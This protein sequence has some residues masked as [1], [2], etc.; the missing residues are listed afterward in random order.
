MS[1]DNT[2][3][4]NYRFGEFSLDPDRQT[5]AL[6]DREVHLRPKSFAVLMSL[7]ERSGQLVTKQML[8]DAAWKE[9]AVSDDSLAHCIADI[10][11]ALGDSGHEMIRTVP[12]RGYIFEHPVTQEFD[13][14]PRPGSERRLRTS[15]VASIALALFATT[16]LLAGFGP[17]NK[18][19]EH[20]D[21]SAN[22]PL[23]VSATD[24][25]NDQK[26]ANSEYQRGRFFF[27][28]RGSG[29]LDRAEA[30]FKRALELDPSYGAA[31]TG[32]AGL[33]S[34]RCAHGHTSLD[35][36]LPILGD[37]TRNAVS[38]APGSA[39]AHARRAFYYRLR[40]KHRDS[41]H[42]FDVALA[43]APDN[44]HMLAVR[45]GK[46]VERGHLDEAIELQ[47]QAIE[48]RPTS[49]LLQH[50]LTWYLLAA[51]R[52]AEAAEEARIYRALDPSR[53]DDRASIFVDVLI[54][55]G[56][57]EQALALAHNIGDDRLRNRSLAIIHDELGRSELA[58]AT[59]TRLM[60]DDDK[61]A[62][63]YVAEVLAQ[64]G[65]N[66]RALQILSGVMNAPNSNATERCCME[67]PALLL[68]SPY[69]IE[70]RSSERWQTLY[71]QTQKALE[72]QRTVA[73]L[74]APR[75]PLSR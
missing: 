15:L 6:G 22:Q 62:I 58:D 64:R 17:G 50:N 20:D 7:V 56:N 26:L 59:L 19:S 10:R 35:E 8:C 47:K 41:E 29:D 42:H 14:Q 46:L 34:V 51:G 25:P 69:L 37:A 57:H 70:L 32:L 24:S 52:V 4:S 68:L 53:I 44:V 2:A 23:T 40:G 38:L 63:L 33:Y 1:I 21:A 12:R 3:H 74:A 30:S 48:L 61:L 45:A 73:S 36:C 16:M 67:R 65:D 18:A 31:W 55:Q 75:A 9:T 72:D 11:R 49:V 13:C 54:L 71:A 39:E 5:L 28:R 60:Q 43:L 27:D 66:E